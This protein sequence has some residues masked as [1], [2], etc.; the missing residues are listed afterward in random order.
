MNVI[1]GS[2]LNKLNQW[3]FNENKVHLNMNE[4]LYSQLDSFGVVNFIIWI[5]EIEPHLINFDFDR[6]INLNPDQVVRC[7]KEATT[8]T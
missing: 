6:L 1:Q 8:A 4:P 3:F 5:Q 2:L 7:L